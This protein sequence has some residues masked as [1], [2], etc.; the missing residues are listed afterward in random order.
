MRVGLIGR[1][2]TGAALAALLVGGL[3][4]ALIVTIGNQQDATREAKESE[5]TI[6][7]AALTERIVLDVQSSVRG[8]LLTGDER[9]LGPWRNAQTALPRT[10]DRLVALTVGEP[11]QFVRARQIHADALTYFREFANPVVARART[12]RSDAGRALRES[13]Q[14]GGRRVAELRADLAQLT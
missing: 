8:Y 3:L 14:G 7:L 2:L 11:G 9:L 5:Q 10:V 12:D 4:I 13:L 6:A 1:T